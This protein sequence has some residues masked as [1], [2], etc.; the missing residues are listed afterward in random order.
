AEEATCRT[1]ERGRRTEDRRGAGGRAT[2]EHDAKQIAGRLGEFR[3]Q[4]RVRRNVRARGLRVLRVAA[5]FGIRQR[6]SGGK[7]SSRLLWTD[8]R[9]GERI[10]HLRGGERPSPGR[11]LRAERR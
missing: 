10:R 3:R 9:A 2:Q 4:A 7:G 1:T 6:G 11:L 5:G 8:G